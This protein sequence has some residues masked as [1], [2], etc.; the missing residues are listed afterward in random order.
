MAVLRAI[1]RFFARIG[2]WIR[3]TAWVQPLLIVGGIF[4][5]IFSIPYLTKWVKSWFQEGDAAT[6]Y[7]KKNAISW[8]GITDKSGNKSQ[9]D[10]FFSYLEDYDNAKIENT[11]EYKKYGSKFF[12]NFVQEGCEGCEANYEGFKVLQDNWNKDEKL[13]FFD[14]E[15]NKVKKGQ[16]GYEEFKIFNIFIDKNDPDAEDKRAYFLR[17]V[18]GNGDTRYSEFFNEAAATKTPYQY[19]IGKGGNYYSDMLC[20]EEETFKSPVTFLI[21]ME[22]EAEEGYEIQGYGVTEIFE[23]IEAKEGYSGGW[24]KALSLFD[25]WNH[26][27]IFSNDY[28][29]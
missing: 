24:G 6:A 9:I 12:L 16:E 26:N 1:G 22:W 8:D 7:Y 13:S 28:K 23:Q 25:C 19:N 2:R 29:K 27:D 21:D 5:I 3:D 4:A 10:K 17:F 18:Y 15:G 20:Q 11:A 14:D